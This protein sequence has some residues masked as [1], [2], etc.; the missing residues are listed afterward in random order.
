MYIWY[1]KTNI[2][3]IQGGHCGC[4]SYLGNLARAIEVFLG[5]LGNCSED[6]EMK[7]CKL[8]HIQAKP[9]KTDIPPPYLKTL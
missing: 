6:I 8:E 9:A 2:H 1:W 5:F 3:S 7:D 4:L